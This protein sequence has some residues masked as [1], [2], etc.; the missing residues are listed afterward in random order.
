MTQV[1]WLL[2]SRYAAGECDADERAEV[3][4]WLA[5]NPDRQAWLAAI[6]RAAALADRTVSPERRAELKA[7]M[8]RRI[9]GMRA[10]RRPVRDVYPLAPR[11]GQQLWRIAAAV[12][13]LVGGSLATYTILRDSGAPVATVDPTV[14][15]ITTPRGQRMSLRLADGTQ[16]LLA[17]ASTLRLPATYGAGDR[18]VELEGEAAF[19]VTHDEAR[20]FIVRAGALVAKDLGTRFVVRAYADEPDADVVVAEGEVAVSQGASADSVLLTPGDRAQV[21]ADGGVIVARGVQ[22]DSYFGWTE[23]R[24]VFRGTP[25]RE[26][27]ARIERWHDVEIH[28]ASPAIGERQFTAAFALE[29]SAS[30]M[31]GS[32]A[33]ALQLTVRQ[34]GP[35]QYTL[36]AD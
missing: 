16:V 29:E 27:A 34:T 28:L 1:D 15:T 11:L 5:D 7:D 12:V 24:L 30:Q 6:P 8:E 17:P 19:T 20:P 33:A 3:E 36:H 26:A 23:G 21:R 10:A 18:T 32:I 14:H 13:L 31:I 9:A 25:L 4:R 2:L 35:R 22:L